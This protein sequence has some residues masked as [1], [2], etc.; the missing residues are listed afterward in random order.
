MS[1]MKVIRLTNGEQ[2]ICHLSEHDDDNMLISMGFTVSAEQGTNRI[3]YHPFAPWSSATGEVVL[4]KDSI[5]FISQPA[6]FLIDQYQDLLDGKLLP[7]NVDAG[8]AE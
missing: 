7:A 2:L 5:S 8:S 4:K 6:S 1:E 3:M